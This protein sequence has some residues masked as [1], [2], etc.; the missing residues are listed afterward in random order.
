MDGQYIHAPDS[1]MHIASRAGQTWIETATRQQNYTQ[2][3][4][5]LY[6]PIKKAFFLSVL[7]AGKADS[8]KTLQD[9]ILQKS[10]RLEGLDAVVKDRLEKLRKK[11]HDLQTCQGWVNMRAATTWPFTSGMSSLWNTIRTFN[12]P[13]IRHLCSSSCRSWDLS[14]FSLLEFWF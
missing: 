14:H 4:R 3:R 2:I 13:R 11:A 10:T 6:V 9:E 12:S 5:W 1:L 7:F 8:L